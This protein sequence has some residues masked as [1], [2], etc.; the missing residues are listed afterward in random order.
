MAI[1]INITREFT[2]NILEDLNQSIPNNMDIIISSS[3]KD[4]DI[5][6]CGTEEYNEEKLKSM[7]NL[8]M[9]C[10][11]GSGVDNI[12]Y[13]YC[14]KNNITVLNTPKAIALSVAEFTFG[15]MIYA[16][17]RIN[18]IDDKRIYGRE[19]KECKIGIIGHGNIGNKL[20]DIMDHLRLNNVIHDLKY[21]TNVNSKESILESCDIVSLHIPK[22]D[23]SLNIDNNNYITYRE[24]SLMKTDSVLI[25]NSRAGIVCESDVKLFAQQNPNFTYITD[26]YDDKSLTNVPNIITTPHIASYTKGA[27][28]AMEIECINKVLIWIKTNLS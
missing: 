13:K 7:P 18:Q 6:I 25:N 9:I 1:K 20:S 22:Y 3:Y 15:Q 24:L 14:L 5:L 19:L 28:Y 17:R 11:L 16:L 26:T 8:K 4:A 21:R 12:D 2:S 10:R 23:T 27:R